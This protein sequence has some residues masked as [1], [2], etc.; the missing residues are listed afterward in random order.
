MHLRS[1]HFV[2][3]NLQ[4]KDKENIR[5]LE[6]SRPWI[7]GLLRFKDSLPGADKFDVFDYFETLWN[8]YLEMDYFWC[9]YRKD[10]EFCGDVQLERDG[11]DEYHLYIQIMED[12]RIEGLGKELFERLISEIVE[13]TGAKHLEFELWNDKDR[14]KEIFEE[15][16]YNLAD[17]YW[18]YDC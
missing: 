4:L 11:E 7:K 10:G 13:E 12:A 9:I 15:A 1:E 2:I 5:A 16:G 3:D 8:D 18:Q 14:S 6:E 17:G